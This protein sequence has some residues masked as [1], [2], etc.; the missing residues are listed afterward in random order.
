VAEHRAFRREV[1]EI[2]S[3]DYQPQALAFAKES[4]R[5]ENLDVHRH[6]FTGFQ[7]K[8]SLVQ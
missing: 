7:A 2:P 4:A 3:L 5:G 6:A 1:V 8:L